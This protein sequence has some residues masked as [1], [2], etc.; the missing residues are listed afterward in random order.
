MGPGHVAATMQTVV[1]LSHKILAFL[2]QSL[3]ARGQWSCF[4]FPEPFM[5]DANSKG[6]MFPLG[7]KGEKL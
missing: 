5:A 4:L 1:P 2:Q 7:Q 3:L 6:S